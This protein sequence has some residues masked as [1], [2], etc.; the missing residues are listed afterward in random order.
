M[1]SV[2]MNC[3]YL[4]KQ[5]Q[6]YNSSVEKKV[7]NVTPSA[8]LM[9]INITENWMKTVC[10]RSNSLSQYPVKHMVIY[11]CLIGLADSFAQTGHFTTYKYWQNLAPSVP[12]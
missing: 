4:L 1:I 9:H 8:D 12:P 11:D 10:H 2:I 3:R 7:F 5:V 6:K